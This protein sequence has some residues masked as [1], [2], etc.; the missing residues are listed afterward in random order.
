MCSWERTVYDCKHPQPV[1]RM[2]YSC[3]VYVRY[4]YGECR[5]NER[6]DYVYTVL[7]GEWCPK[8]CE[9]YQYVNF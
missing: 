4:I 6:R 9:L 3:K 8:C 7:G 5:F 2:A 1:R